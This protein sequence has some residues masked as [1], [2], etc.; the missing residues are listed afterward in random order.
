MSFTAAN[1]YINYPVKLAQKMIINDE[2]E[3]KQKT[4]DNHFFTQ[5]PVA[6]FER[7]VYTLGD[8]LYG[9][10]WEL[11]FHGGPKERLDMITKH[12][13]TVSVKRRHLPAFQDNGYI[14]FRFHKGGKTWLKAKLIKTGKNMS[15]SGRKAVK[16]GSLVSRK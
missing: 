14:S 1:A 8:I 13:S 16:I 11:S 7:S 6:I 15:L 10:I 9:I 12:T 2:V 5:P 4:K 3:R